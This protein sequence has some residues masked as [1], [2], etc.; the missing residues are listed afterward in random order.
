MAPFGD[1][2]VTGDGV[3]ASTTFN[4]LKTAIGSYFIDKIPANTTV[5]FQ[6]P[7]YVK[8]LLDATITCLPQ[9]KQSIVQANV[10]AALDQLF[11]IDNVVFADRISTNDVS[12]AINSVEGV[13]YVELEKLTR[14]DEDITKVVDQKTLSAGGLA[15]LR[16]TAV[17]GLKIGDTVKVTGIDADFNGVY[18]VTTIPSTTTFTYTAIGT[19]ISATSVIGGGVTKLQVNE[20]L[21]DLNEIPEKGTWTLTLSGGITI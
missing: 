17:H 4:N 8:A 7:S 20:I 2:G 18:V 10:T 16:T 12:S 3:T 21:C 6:P 1:K 13:A 5:T 9:Y 11:D 15:T 19:A 14:L